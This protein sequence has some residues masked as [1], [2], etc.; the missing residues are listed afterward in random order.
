MYRRLMINVLDLFH[1]AL[2]HI[3]HAQN[4]P[5]CP[6][7]PLQELKNRI[8]TANDSFVAMCVAEIWESVDSTLKCVNLAKDYCDYLDAHVIRPKDLPTWGKHYRKAASCIDQ[9]Y[10]QL[11]EC[12]IKEYSLF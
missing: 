11:Y 10:D 2:I 3:Q 12:S 1:N 5:D 4:E 9:I 7:L 8:I 6:A